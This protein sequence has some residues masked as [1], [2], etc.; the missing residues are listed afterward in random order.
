VSKGWL[1]FGG[2]LALGATYLLIREIPSIR[3]EVHL[4]RM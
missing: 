1:L 2:L 4:M 3:R